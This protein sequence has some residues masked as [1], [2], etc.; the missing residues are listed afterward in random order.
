[1]SPGDGPGYNDL[2]DGSHDTLMVVE[3]PDGQFQWV[4]PGDLHLDRMSY[5]INDGSSRGLGSRLG[6]QMSCQLARAY[7]T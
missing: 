2:A 5:G 3:V 6:R 4:E 1:M 7:E